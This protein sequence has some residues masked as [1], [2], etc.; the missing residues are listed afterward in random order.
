MAG[1]LDLTPLPPSSLMTV[2]ILERWKKRF[3]KVLYSLMAWPFIPGPPLPFFRL[4][5]IILEMCVN[6]YNYAILVEK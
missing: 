3:Q 6:I 4:P 5:L 2:E 1:P